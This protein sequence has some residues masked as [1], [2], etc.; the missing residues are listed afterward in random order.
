MEEDLKESAVKYAEHAENKISRLQQAYLKKYRSR[1]HAAGSPN[2]NFGGRVSA[3]F[4]GRRDDLRE[5]EPITIAAESEGRKLSTIY[6][7]GPNLVY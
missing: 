3:L 6:P 7:V 2:N 1:Q 5:P 4:R